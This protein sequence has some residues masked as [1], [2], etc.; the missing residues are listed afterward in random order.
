MI[1]P[2]NPLYEWFGLNESL[3]LSI[4]KV[5]APVLD[6]LMLLVTWLGHPRLF[7]FYIV[8]VLLLMWFKPD[9]MPQRNVVVLAVSYVITS[10]LL[11]P[12]IKVVLDFPRP[13]AVL[14]EQAVVILGSPDTIHSF[15]SGHSAYAVLTAAS[16]A[17]DIPRR[18]KQ[19]LIIFALL[20]CVSRISVGA[21]YPA[22][23]LGGATLSILIVSTV[24]F[25]INLKK[26]GDQDIVEKESQR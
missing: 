7:V 3:F 6:Q 19:A 16:L 11:V 8:F 1:E 22:D 4:N 18:A 12:I 23:V 21:H 14:G 10:M 2:G 17:P 15:P 5:H 26:V 25:I 20:V 13:F 9:M 24:R